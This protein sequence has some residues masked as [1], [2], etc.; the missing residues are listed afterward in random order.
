MFFILD[1][2]L[3]CRQM[4]DTIIIVVSVNSWTKQGDG[5]GDTKLKKLCAIYKF[6]K[7]KLRGSL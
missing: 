2:Q 6:S 1:K 5:V 3:K 7:G 4:V